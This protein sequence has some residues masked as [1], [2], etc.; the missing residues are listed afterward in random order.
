MDLEIVNDGERGLI[1]RDRETGEEVPVPIDE[2]DVKSTYSETGEFTSLNTEEAVV[3]Q[4]T[5][6]GTDRLVIKKSDGTEMAG[7]YSDGT[8]LV[9][10]PL[11][12]DEVDV[13]G[14]LEA[15]NIN[16][17]TQADMTNGL[18]DKLVMTGPN[19]DVL[20]ISD[21]GTDRIAVTRT[22]GTGD[23][24]I[25]MID[26]SDGSVFLH[27]KEADGL[28]ELP[29][30]VKVEEGAK[31]IIKGSEGGYVEHDQRGVDVTTSELQDGRVATY[32]SDGTADVTGDA[33]DLIYAVNDGG[34]IKTS[35]I[36]AVSNAT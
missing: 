10:D 14:D 18:L 29:S 2:L 7:I 20:Q 9:I 25:K 34:T 8:S 15:D 1:A 19:V 35:V 13:T 3:D 24:G 28:T 27:Y 31:L 26:D 32:I 36:A 23:G 5:D 22:S 12:S 33:G 11:S 17:V 16:V 4:S 6:D 21:E 30:T